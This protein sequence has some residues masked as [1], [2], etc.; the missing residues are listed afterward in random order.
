MPKNR[1]NNN[2]P[3]KKSFKSFRFNTLDW[4]CILFG[5]SVSI[6]AP[7]IDHSHSFTYT[8]VSVIMLICGIFE[9]ILGIKG[10]RSNYIFAIINTFASIYIAW[11]DQFYGNMAI[12][13]YYIPIC[14]FGF[15]SWGKHRDKKKDVIARKL[16]I[17][18]ILLA[19][20]I[21]IATS[22]IL[23]ILL[24]YFGGHATLLDSTSTILIIFASILGVLRYREQWIL[25]IVVDALT[26]IMWL[27]TGSPATIA[28][29]A[30]YVLGSIYGYFNW[31]KFIRK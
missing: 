28:M 31:R 18:Q 25:W 20:T 11:S 23:N 13:A 30:F 27:D 12:N 4:L 5:I 26:L 8:A 2:K 17:K 16:S 10:R 19:T 3:N 29:R 21:F 15:Y 14:L 9:M 6:I 1:K 7:L 24:Q 22:I